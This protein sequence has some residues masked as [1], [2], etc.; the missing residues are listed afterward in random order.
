MTRTTAREIAVQLS[1]AAS[2]SSCAMEDLLDAFF[3]EE[4]YSS[5][6]SEQELFSDR[7]D[8]KQM[9][10]IRTLTTL[11]AEKRKELDS[12]IER[13]ARGW[14][15]ERISRTALAV[16]RCALCEILYMEEIPNAAAINEAVE[17]DKKYDEPDT[18]A[19]VNGVLGGFMRGEFGVK[20]TDAQE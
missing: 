3:S 6:V 10:Y 5:L 14:K 19:F 9:G 4:H 16:L 8:E 17:L 12:Y 11:A 13:Y 7:P 15:P 20:N 2:A 1:F 18:V